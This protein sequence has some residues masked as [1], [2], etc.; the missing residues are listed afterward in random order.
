MEPRKT[1]SKREYAFLAL[2]QNGRCPCCSGKLDFGK[3]RQ[4]VDE[5]LQ[6]LADGGS[7]ELGNRALY[8][9]ACAKAKTIKEVTPRARSKRISEGR[10]QADKRQKAKAEGRYRPMGGKGFEKRKTQWPKGRKIESRGF[11]K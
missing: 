9:A 11:G 7:N 1:L 10:T 6:P 4:V 2:R 8:C 3:P 5:H